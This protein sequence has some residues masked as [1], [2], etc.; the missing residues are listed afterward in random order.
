MPQST[1]RDDANRDRLWSSAAFFVTLAVAVALLRWSMRERRH[2]GDQGAAQESRRTL[3]ENGPDG[4]IDTTMR[5]LP[6]RL[7]RPR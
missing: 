3:K 5:Q 6:M 7:T 1:H 4:V 2:R